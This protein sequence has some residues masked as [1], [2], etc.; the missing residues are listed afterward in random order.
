M[1]KIFHTED[2]CYT[3]REKGVGER[4]GRKQERDVEGRVKLRLCAV[5]LW[6]T[7][8]NLMISSH[9][10]ILDTTANYEQSRDPPEAIK[11]RFVD[12]KYSTQQSLP[13]NLSFNLIS[14]SCC[15][16]LISMK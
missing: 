8:T 15:G 2:S 9:S 12:N 3:W 6:P 10:Q 16:D 14:Q 5:I 1:M 11:P 7:D 13:V 4:G